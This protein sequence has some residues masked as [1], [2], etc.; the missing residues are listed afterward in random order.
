MQE[1]PL[2]RASKLGLTPLPTVLAKDIVEKILNDNAEASNFA[3][4]WS[5][6]R[7]ID[8]KTLNSETD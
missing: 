5:D 8:T 2:F 6:M 3:F 7:R 1:K 4:A